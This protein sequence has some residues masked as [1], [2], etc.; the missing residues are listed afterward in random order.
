VVETQVFEYYRPYSENA[1][2]HA[3]LG[4]TL[5]GYKKERLRRANSVELEKLNKLHLIKNNEEI[6]LQKAR[7]EISRIVHCLDLPV[8][9][10]TLVFKNFKEIVSNEM[11]SHEPEEFIP[12]PDYKH[13][14]DISLPDSNYKPENLDF[15]PDKDYRPE[16]EEFIPV[17]EKKSGEGYTFKTNIFKLLEVES[18][19]MLEC[20]PQ[21]EK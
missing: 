12:N 18:K 10:G 21:D 6:A 9:Y 19:M 17:S 4:T 11:L 3:V 2:Q 8:F 14:N 15:V 5:L 1:I 7:L 13:D 20:I 16:Q